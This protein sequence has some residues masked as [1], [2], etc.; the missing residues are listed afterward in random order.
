M[1]LRVS[2]DIDFETTVLMPRSKDRDTNY[3]AVLFWFPRDAK[4][5]EM[6]LKWLK[7][8]E[9][10]LVAHG[11]K[12]NITKEDSNY[13]FNI[14]QRFFSKDNKFNVTIKLT[15]KQMKKFIK[16]MGSV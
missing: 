16:N 3:I 14:S 12:F 2:E 9:K 13:I 1:F 5:L 4:E 11:C 10:E 8:P 6:L 15:E 7:K